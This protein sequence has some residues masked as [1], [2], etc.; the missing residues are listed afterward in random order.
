DRPG[1]SPRSAPILSDVV[2]GFAYIRTAPKIS[3]LFLL[4]VGFAVLARPFIEL[5]PAIAGEVLQGGPKTL[6]TLMSAQGVGALIG[7]VWML[8]AKPT[9]HLVRITL[10][11]ALGLAT[12][13]ILFSLSTHLHL[14]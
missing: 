6:S 3:M 7:A 14:V 1:L 11:A 12:T 10:G 9:E 8:R 2:S 4:A 13:L 5:F